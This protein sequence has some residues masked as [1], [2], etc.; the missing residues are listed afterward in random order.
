M[1]TSVMRVIRKRRTGRKR[2]KME[3][4][5]K[6]DWSDLMGKAVSLVFLAGPLMLMVFLFWLLGT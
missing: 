5:T 3:E 6:T 1:M 2:G 4:K